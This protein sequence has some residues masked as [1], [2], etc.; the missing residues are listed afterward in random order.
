MTSRWVGRGDANGNFDIAGVPDGNYTLAWW[1]E[2]Q[3]YNLNF[4]NV[5]VSGGETVQMGQLP[6]NGWWT[7]YTGH[8][9]EDLNRNGVRDAGEPGVPDFA[10]DV[11]SS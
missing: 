6:L 11:A 9:F 10:V 3:D 2:P 5:T 4:I 1:D 8:V 7:E